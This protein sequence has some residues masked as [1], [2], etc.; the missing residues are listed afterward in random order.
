MKFRSTPTNLSLAR[1][2]RHSFAAFLTFFLLSFFLA[3][4]FLDFFLEFAATSYTSSQDSAP[5]EDLLE[6]ERQRSDA[7]DAL[8]KR[9]LKSNPR[10]FDETRYGLEG[11]YAVLGVEKGNLQADGRID[12]VRL[13][14]LRKEDGIYN[15]ALLLEITPLE[16]EEEPFLIHLP[17]D[18]KGFGS[19]MEL[20]NFV[21]ARKSEILLSVESANDAVER[22]LIVEVS[23]RQGR[24]IYDSRTAAIPTIEGKFFD[25]YRA[26]VFVR[27]TGA[28][29]LID[30][31]SRKESYN[32]KRVYHESTGALRSPVT[33]WKDRL[34]LL[35]PV[36][37]DG[38]GLYELRGVADLVG[39]TRADR[40][41]YVEFTLRYDGA[42]RVRDSWVV[43][44]ED[45][46]N[47]PLPRRLQ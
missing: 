22:L 9:L 37:M 35:Q 40:I 36:D 26:E 21:S 42:W 39:V 32:E 43:P 47:L 10:F 16:L 5:A 31:S 24:V 27:E 13:L 2:K 7:M 30:L 17:E 34:S 12:Q 18:V 3:F 14:A 23:E 28:R 20:K 4:F 15:R 8:V 6:G 33:V 38:D 1:S 19:K 25:N 46:A 44:A 11:N 41:A 45:L 29:A